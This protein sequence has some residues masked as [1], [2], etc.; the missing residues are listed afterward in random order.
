MVQ[1]FGFPGYFIYRIEVRSLEPLELMKGVELELVE[2]L[3]VED[4]RRGKNSC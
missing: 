1:C 2:D 3:H 4:R